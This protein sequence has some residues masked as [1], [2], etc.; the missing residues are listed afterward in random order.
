MASL[1][2]L[3]ISL[4]IKADE[5]SLKRIDNGIKSLRNGAFALSAAFTGAVYG[6]NKFVDGSLQGVVALQNLSNQTGLAIEGLQKWQQAGQL[7]NLA[8]SAEQIAGSIGNVQKNL[9]QIRMGQGNLAPF[10]LL[11]IDVM[12]QDAFGVLDQLRNSI[13]GLDSATATNLIT[14]IGL[15]PD[16]INLLRLSRKEFEALSENT[17]LNKKQREEI[18]KVGTSIK[19]LQLRMG[20]LKD[21]AV[22]K[23]APLLNDLV[24]DF[25]KWLSDNGDKI[26]NTMS[27]FAKGFAMFTQAIGNA[28][29]VLTGFLSN[30]TGMESGTK[31]L[32]IAFGAL[33]LAMRP[34]LLG[35]TAL[36]LVLDDIAVFQRGGESLIGS[37]FDVFKNGELTTQITTIATAI[38]VLSLALGGITGSLKTIKGLGGIGA[39]LG[40]TGLI[41]QAPELGKKFASFLEEKTNI[42]DF[43]DKLLG[44]DLASINQRMGLNTALNANITNNVT[45]NGIQEPKAV[46]DELSRGLD[47]ITTQSLKKVQINQGNNLK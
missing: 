28:F 40:V 17:F 14:Q 18:D 45:I 11:G 46:K 36:L 13:Q 35:F 33:T 27:D 12:G 26:V 20:A 19:A 32:A 1:G 22:A 39:V 43:I 2:E 15:T 31:A 42:G 29:S 10:Q 24:Q 25:F 3:F 47:V 23:I 4:G 8:I 21:Q 37:F 5:A 9:A 44:N 6:L 41:S 30:I 7:S 16:F 34:M 38:G